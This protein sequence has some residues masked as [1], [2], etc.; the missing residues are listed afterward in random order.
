MNAVPGVPEEPQEPQEPE[1]RFEP[2]A[3]FEVSAALRP[4]LARAV[5]RAGPGL[6][7]LIL[8][9]S[10]ATGEAVWTSFEGRDVTLSDVD[11]YAVVRREAATATPLASAHERRA[12]GLLAPVEVAFVTLA[13]LAHMPARPGT[14]E[15]ARS[16]R[17]V[18]GD[19]GVLARLPRWEPAAIAAE[20]R[21]LLL[22]NRAF[23]LL[24]ADALWPA[25]TRSAGA[26]GPV[27]AAETL[28]RL[29][30]RHALLK[31]AL[32]LAS[33]R[34][35]T[36]GELP[37]GAGARVA[38]AR[39]LGAPDGAPS[40]LA[41]AWDGLAPLW[42]EALAW[43]AGAAR[44]VSDE[45]Q[46]VS[47]RAVTR[48][49]CMAWW[50]EGGRGAAADPWERALGVAARGSLARRLRRSLAAS[51]GAGPAPGRIER[52]RRAPAGTPANRIH[53][54]GALLM[55][56]AASAPGEPQLPAGA[57][58]ALHALG[59]TRASGFTTAAREALVAWDRQLHA[60]ERT[61]DLD[62]LD[63]SRP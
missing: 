36:H 63:R 10:H 54:S 47:W 41:G 24:W 21:L 17:V 28:Q 22:E 35:L 43:R 39:D 2:D 14:V 15:L 7:A 26:A 55:L 34:T 61:A 18:A 58:R 57:L 62:E 29:R 11:L 1:A 56:A 31:T 59:V 13:G 30:A 48:A 27:D 12:W 19:P 5:E 40:W 9:G 37:A 20:E 4:A 60:G 32:E 42:E 53:G 25:R 50:A 49:W 46:A 52:L 38:R 45:A 51:P 6:Q 44:L 8:S 33:A 16:G 3:G 23:E